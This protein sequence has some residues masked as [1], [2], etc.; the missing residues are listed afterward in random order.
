MFGKRKYKHLF[1]DLDHT[2]WDFESSAR[3]TL[4]ELF[5]THG[6][7]NHIESKELFIKEYQ[8][9]NRQLWDLY[10][11]N[12]VDKETLRLTRFA[13]TLEKF[14]IFDLQLSLELADD[15]V[16]LSPY[17]GMLF[18]G[19]HDVL[20][21]LMKK[22][23]LHIITNGF[24]EVQHIKIKNSD[25]ERYFEHIF[26]SEEVGFVKPQPQIFNHAM[27]TA[28]A[29][30]SESIMIGDNYEVD[31]LGAAAVGMHTVFFNP[32]KIMDD[33]KCTFQIY[34]LKELIDLLK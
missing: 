10:H 5:E 20:D 14:E 4:T 26:I 25:L 15:Y 22:H 7:R 28:N 2:L 34:E 29:K 12:L 8:L 18:P 27:H 23:K 30:S 19:V 32:E 33:Y 11:K 13:L 31:I 9:I 21:V 6:L 3:A 24:S 17:K 1:F 16:K